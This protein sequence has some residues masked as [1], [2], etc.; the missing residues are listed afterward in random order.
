VSDETVPFQVD[1]D[2]G[3]QLPVTIGIEPKAVR[4]I[5]PTK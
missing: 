1:G 3:G 5:A 2:P 4:V